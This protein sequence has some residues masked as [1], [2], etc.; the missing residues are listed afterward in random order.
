MAVTSHYYP[1]GCTGF[2][3]S[4]VAITG[5]ARSLYDFNSREGHMRARTGP[6]VSNEH[7]C[8]QK[9]LKGPKNVRTVCLKIVNARLTTKV[10]TASV[11]VP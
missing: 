4:Y 8:P 2:E 6:I 1:F 9:T 3:A 10:Y 11:S 5:P 7:V